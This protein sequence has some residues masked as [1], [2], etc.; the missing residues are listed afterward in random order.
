[1]GND[2]PI[3]RANCLEREKRDERSAC[4]KKGSG[5]WISFRRGHG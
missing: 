1:M 5:A 3:E 4:P 2:T